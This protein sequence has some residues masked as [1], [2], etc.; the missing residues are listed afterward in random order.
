MRTLRLG[1][2]LVLAVGALVA[3]G[4]DDD[5]DDVGGDDDSGEESSGGDVPLENGLPF[6]LGLFSTLCEDQTGFEGATAYDATSSGVHPIV[7]LEQR[8]VGNEGF[9]AASGSEFPAGWLLE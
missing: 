1:L 2:C 9:A 4:G 6:S 5:D 8:S 7:I 3:C